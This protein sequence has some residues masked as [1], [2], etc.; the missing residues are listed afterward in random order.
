M[1]VVHCLVAV[2]AVVA[3]TMAVLRL[4]IDST[5][6]EIEA[7]VLLFACLL[8]VPLCLRWG[9]RSCTGG[10][11]QDVPGA[12][13][14]AARKCTPTVLVTLEEQLRR[15]SVVVR[16]RAAALF[17]AHKF[18]ESI[19][20]QRSDVVADVSK[21]GLAE[22]MLNVDGCEL[23]PSCVQLDDRQPEWMDLRASQRLPVDVRLLLAR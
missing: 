15:R 2:A 8:G 17:G 20:D 13:S 19:S 5:R 16:Q 11:C 12:T 6:S 14:G 3:A 1:R 21:L 4:D 18:D 22:R 7:V 23:I 9:H 10:V